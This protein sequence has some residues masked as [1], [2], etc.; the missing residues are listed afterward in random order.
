ML[1]IVIAGWMALG[2]TAGAPPVQATYL[3]TLSNFSGS[4][5]YDWVRI[6]V[7]PGTNEI[8]VLYQSLV[9]IFSPS[10]MEV[11]SFGDDLDLG[12]VLDAAV[13]GNGDVLLLSYK[14]SRALVTRCNFRGVPVAS[15]EI[16]NLPAGLAFVANR[17]FLRNDRLYFVSTNA[18]SVII[19]DLAGEFREHLD[20][21]ALVDA[22]EKQKV[23]AEIIGF[24]VDGEGNLYFTV[25]VLFRVFKVSPDRTVTSFGRPGSAPGRFG[26]LSGVAADS[27]GNL[28]VADKLRCVVM[29]FDRGFTFLTEFGYRGARPENLI[30]PDDIAVDERDRVYV[31]QG[32]SRGVSVFALSGG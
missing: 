2:A 6:H 9:R 21:L 7:D 10:G 14:D 5:P 18:S 3:Y 22:D 23:G 15:L 13:D 8:Y 12:Q 1:A 32:R 20:L 17:M 19:T 4:L 27:H 29:V 30:V 24:A 16:R 28:L 26:V 25:P 31:S 11:Y